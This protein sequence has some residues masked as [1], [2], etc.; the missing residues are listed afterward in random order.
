M[1]LLLLLLLYIVSLVPPPLYLRLSV[2][3]TGQDAVIWKVTLA[4]YSRFVPKSLHSVGFTDEKLINIDFSVPVSKEDL[5]GFGSGRV[6]KR[7][8]LCEMAL[9]QQ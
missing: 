2:L 6:S 4:S 1:I 5:G 8:F 7:G 3:E 9:Q